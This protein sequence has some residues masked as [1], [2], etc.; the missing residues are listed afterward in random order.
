VLSRPSEKDLEVLPN[1]EAVGTFTKEDG[2][3][4]PKKASS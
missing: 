1:A 3:T 2:E 4:I